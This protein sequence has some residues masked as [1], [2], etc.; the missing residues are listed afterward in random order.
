MSFA[1]ALVQR[2]WRSKE[3]WGG[4]GLVHPRPVVLGSGTGSSE[5]QR[6]WP[7]GD[8]GPEGPEKVR[9]GIGATRGSGKFHCLFFLFFCDAATTFSA[10]FDR[11]W[12]RQFSPFS[13]PPRPP[14]KPDLPSHC[15]HTYTFVQGNH[16]RLP[17]HKWPHSPPVPQNPQLGDRAAPSM[18][19]GMRAVGECVVGACVFRRWFSFARARAHTHARTHTRRLQ[20]IIQTLQF[21]LEHVDA[22][23]RSAEGRVLVLKIVHHPLHPRVD[24]ALDVLVFCQLLCDRLNQ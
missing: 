16:E 21:A 12:S 13:E 18:L 7:G 22:L 4:G 17:C 11:K 24:V 9:M 10:T 14:N 2:K 6:E 19:R 23:R 1:R 8:R 20:Q 5:T 3:G 15:T